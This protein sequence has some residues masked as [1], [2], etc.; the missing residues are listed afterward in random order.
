[1]SSFTLVVCLFAGTAMAADRGDIA[2]ADFEG[3]DYAGWDA[4]G[5]AFGKHPARG[6]FPGQSYPDGFL[7]RG[8]VNSYMGGDAATGTLTS[9]PFRIERTYLNFLVGG[10]G[11]AGETCVDLLID[12]RVV[13][14]A[15]GPNTEPGG[16]ERLEWATWDVREFEGRAATLRIVDARTLNWG[17]ICVDQFVQSDRK[18]APEPATRKLVVGRRYLHIPVTRN[19][20]VRRVRV[21]SDGKALHDFDVNLTDQGEAV[22]FW[23]FL[24]LEAV[25]GRDLTVKSMLPPASRALDQL[26]LDD[27]VPGAEGHY[28]E[29]YRPQFHFT[30]RRGW[31][32][33]PNGLVW[34]D[35]LFHLFFQ[36][37]PFGCG[38]GTTYWGHAV[39][40]DL[41]HWT[42]WPL[43]LSPREYGDGVYSGS[44]VVDLP[45]TSGWGRPGHP[46]MVAAF[47]S[48]RRG[49]C[50]AYSID[51]GRSFVDYAGNPVVTHAGRDPRL[52]WHEPTRRWIMAVYDA[53][54]GHEGIAFHSSAN[55]RAWKLEGRLD[56][57]FECP[58]L[59]ELPIEGHPGESRW[60]I[61]GGDGAYLVGRFDGREFTPETTEKRRV[62]YG[63]FYA[64]QTFSNVPGGRRI[65]V[66]WG[67][68]IS[69][70]DMPFN[71][72]MTVPVELT[73]RQSPDGPRLH[74]N[75]VRELAGLRGVRHEITARMI[76]PGRDV[77]LDLGSDLIEVEA[78][79][80][81]DRAASLSLTVRGVP[82]ELDGRT[83]T[84]RTG[85]IAA[86]LP[87]EGDR[88]SLHV[89]VDRGSIEV[90][91]DDGRV[92][93]SRGVIP[94]ADGK[95][96]VISARGGPIRL[97][98]L[99]AHELRSA[100]PMPTDRTSH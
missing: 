60:V 18:K 92:G 64:G 77:R 98:R 15:S 7:G 67:H 2:V 43:P 4:K 30:A 28:R 66:G 82:V 55:L 69:F 89:L 17:H 50:L 27:D 63:D 81:V 95:G 54:T 31:L 90:F 23:V 39:S 97:T 29:R 56:G 59:F 51:Q 48:V 75:P 3:E 22:D 41:F 79:A 88:V 57:F 9:P 78:E 71:Q 38:W 1:M 49:E 70:P 35:G 34:E 37:N 16:S 19:A 65:Q 24:D 36:H 14:T 83:G 44:A 61:Y 26:K 21:E 32:N 45:N 53:I 52:L 20:R 91:G 74:A 5:T 84:L 11:F 46:A 47:T 96:L 8:L 86:P 68:G 94:P 93:I 72:Q 6:A 13:R 87:I 12:G 76:E 33:D 40:P 100:W 80:T 73:L 42:E 62:W 58:D 25:K 99:V 10:G 85:E